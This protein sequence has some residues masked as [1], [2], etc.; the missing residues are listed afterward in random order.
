[1]RKALTGLLT[2]VLLSCA[3]L[4]WAQ[5]TARTAA[6]T[7]MSL[8]DIET[9]WAAAYMK[10]DAAAIGEFLADE[11]VSIKSGSRSQSLAPPSKGTDEQ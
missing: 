2:L 4:S 3:S 5:A 6:S 9:K 7:E 11:F 1:M 10:S 8:K